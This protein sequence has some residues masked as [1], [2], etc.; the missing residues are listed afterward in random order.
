MST[1]GKGNNTV[2][3][4]DDAG[5]LLTIIRG[6]N[7]VSYNYDPFGR[8][9]SGIK[10]E[11]GTVIH[12][13][14]FTYNGT[15]PLIKSKTETIDGKTFSVDYSY[16]NKYKRLTDKT[17]HSGFAL[18]YGYND[19]GE[20]N[21]VSALVDN[22]SSGT[23]EVEIWELNSINARGQITQFTQ[24]S[25]VITNLGYDS[26]GL[27]ST[28]ITTY[29]G[30]TLIDY[31]YM[32]K[33][34]GNMQSRTDRLMNQHEEFAYNDLNHQLTS[35]TLYDETGTNTYTQKMGGGHAF[36]AE[37]GNIEKKKDTNFLGGD[38]LT[39][40]IYGTG[41]AGPHALTGFK[42]DPIDTNPHSIEYTFFNKVK[43][44][45]VKNETGTILK[46]FDITYGVDNQRRITDFMDG[47]GTSTLKRYYFD[48]YEEELLP[49]NKTRKIHY[50]SG[51]NGL[52]AMYITDEDQPTMDGLYFAHTDYQGSLIALSKQNSTGYEVVKRYAFD[53][54][55]NRRNPTNWAEALADDGSYQYTARG[56]TMHEHLDGYGLLNMNGR[57]YDPMLSRFLS[58]DPFVQLPGSAMGYNRYAYCLNNPLLFTDPSGNS[59]WTDNWFTRFM[60]WVNGSTVNVREFLYKNNVPDFGVSYNSVK[61]VGYSV[62][63]NPMMYPGEFNNA[64]YA[65]G[66]ANGAIN[67]MNQSR[68][69]YDEIVARYQYD[70]NNSIASYEQSSVAANGEGYIAPMDNTRIDASYLARRGNPVGY[71]QNG[72]FILLGNS[73]W[74]PRERARH[75]DGHP[76]DMS[77]SAPIQ[78]KIAGWFTSFMKLQ[79]NPQNWSNGDTIILNWNYIVVPALT[80]MNINNADTTFTPIRDGVTPPY[81]Y[82]PPTSYD[83]YKRIK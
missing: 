77:Y 78:Y 2:Y 27:P 45:K 58:P 63:H 8:L 39:E 1:D 68:S 53:P 76:I 25:N 38:G 28:N 26:K 65:N 67:R 52:A 23:E 49:G 57:V 70:L 18:N 33:L 3:D 41:D 64:G 6:T 56:Y 42:G 10:K 20:L 44:M 15:T 16:D 47:S 13:Q 21:S 29:N 59:I 34:S 51:G 55:G 36:Y 30:T 62:G 48:D 43:N 54:W 80:I 12:E 73:N 19:G 22:G 82:K 46:Q 71:D 79:S 32:F 35:W 9:L 4:Y 83:Y 31:K 50:I 61:G 72:G 17:Y 24:G 69:F 5:R 81:W 40:F 75:V 7:E 74:Q 11:D 37:N 14:V 60:D 66:Q